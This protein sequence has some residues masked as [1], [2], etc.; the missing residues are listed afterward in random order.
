M[1]KEIELFLDSTHDAVIAINEKEIITIFNRAA[2]KLTQIRA[3]DAIGKPVSKVI[4]TTRLPLVLKS[5]KAELNQIQSLLDTEIITNRKPVYNDQGQI[6]G[7]IAVFRSISEVKSLVEKITNLKEIKNTLKAIIESTQDAISVVDADGYGMMINPAY[8]RLTGY[9][10]E[11]VIGSYCTKDLA[12]GESVH[13]KVLES[14]K[15]V[16]GVRLKVGPKKKEVIVEAAPIIVNGELKGSVAVIHDLTEINRLSNELNQA[17]SIIR[18]LEAKYAFD[19]I[20]GENPTFKKII[21]KAKATANTPATI[22]LRGESGVG[23]ELFAHAIHNKSKRKNAQF[24]RVNCAA[25]NENLLESELFGYE[26]G[27]FTGASKKGRIGL[28]EKADGGTIFLD[29]IGE[30]KKSTQVKLLRVLQEREIVRVGGSK[31]IEVDV[32]II[33][34]TNKNLEQEVKDGTFRRDLY[35]RL[36]VVPINIIPLREHL[37]DVDLLVHHFINKFNQEYGRNI[38]SITAE[39]IEEIKSYDW[40]GNIRE[41]ENFI[42]RTIINMD[43]QDEVIQF[44]HLPVLGLISNRQVSKK[45]EASEVIEEN[46]ENLKEATASFE[47][48]YIEKLL[49]SKDQNRSETAKILGISERSLYYKIKKYNIKI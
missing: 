33:S 43:F 8:T 10:Q 12:S 29:E 24:V 5:G 38:Q 28:F 44:S 7:A 11:D 17:K 23:K 48:K 46:F 22:I 21:K 3:K 4:L 36:N 13:L 47:K 27:A 18:N 9:T 35:Y 26:P 42:G 16:S 1:K 45:N 14:K 20:I 49:S 25:L 40:P 6:I 2:E 30:I 32:R 15:S 39:A 31:S 34:A 37:D 19:D 41:L